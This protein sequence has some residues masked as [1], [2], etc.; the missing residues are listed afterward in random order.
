MKPGTHPSKPAP[1]NVLE[2]FGGDYHRLE[3]TFRPKRGS[4]LPTPP[5]GGKNAKRG[6]TKRKTTG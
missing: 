6:R 1:T 3:S 5:A 2:T 4:M